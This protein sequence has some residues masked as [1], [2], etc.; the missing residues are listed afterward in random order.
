MGVLAQAFLSTVSRLNF[1]SIMD[2]LVVALLI[3]G[4]LSLLKG[5]TAFSVL[6]GIILFFIAVVVI[7][8]IP[9]LVMLNWLLR[10]SL[11][12]LSVA[13]LILFQPELRKVME[14]LGRFHSIFNYPLVRQ[15][16]AG[17]T[18]AIDDLA[19]TCRRLAERRWGGLIVLERT[20]GLQEYVDTGVKIDGAVSLEFLLTIFFPNSP[21]HDGAV[22]VQGDRVVAAGCLLPLTESSG[23]YQELGT[24]HRAA[25]GITEGTDAL[26]LVV[27][28]ETGVISLA[29]NGRLVRNLDESKVQKV[30]ALLYGQQIGER[31]VVS[32]WLRRRAATL[33]GQAP[34]GSN[35][36]SQNENVESRV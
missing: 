22:I 11:P 18:R 17:S 30:L 36:Q 29:N 14:R 26:A 27:S 8:S 7:N 1:W 34:D 24:R 21:L 31:Q 25:I 32:Q 23:H 9:G 12:F 5:T 4:V 35:N 15:N 33:T 2:I 13:L 20:T 6:Y 19:L 16:K 28:E 10:N 3:Y